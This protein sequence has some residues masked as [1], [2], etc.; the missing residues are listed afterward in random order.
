[1]RISWQKSVSMIVITQGLSKD[2]L[3]EN[4]DGCAHASSA[5]YKGM[6]IRKL[7]NELVVKILSELNDPSD[8]FFLHGCLPE[9][10]RTN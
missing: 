10:E 6:S 3:L 8:V 5:K 2:P 1:M 9:M 4:P 7:P